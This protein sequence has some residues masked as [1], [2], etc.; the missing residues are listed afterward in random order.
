MPV[1]GQVTFS[2]E[3]LSDYFWL[4]LIATDIHQCLNDV[5]AITS[6]PNLIKYDF[7]RRNTD[8]LSH[9][10]VISSPH[11]SLCQMYDAIR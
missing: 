5:I 2:I 7:F 11:S 8:V 10:V 9:R 4:F 3:A 1:I 6:K